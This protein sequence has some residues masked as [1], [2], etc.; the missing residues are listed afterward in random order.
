MTS[1]HV[2]AN[3]TRAIRAAEVLH[4]VGVSRTHLYRLIG[5]GE[6]PRPTRLSERISV[7]R[8]SDIEQWLNERLAISKDGGR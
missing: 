2:A 3:E 8:L 6:F 1:N 7:W 5:R 4:R